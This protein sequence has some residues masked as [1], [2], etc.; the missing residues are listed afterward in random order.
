MIID[1]INN[2]SG[3][4]E[5]PLPPR[6]QPTVPGKGGVQ[7]DFLHFFLKRH[8]PYLINNKH[9]SFPEE[10]NGTCIPDLVNFDPVDLKEEIDENNISFIVML[11]QGA[12]KCDQFTLIHI[13]SCAH[14]IQSETLGSYFRLLIG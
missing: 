3:W 9:I 4:A 14:A 13:L 10:S 7:C 8:L 5:Y 12:Q 11:Q 2:W 1:F 6:R